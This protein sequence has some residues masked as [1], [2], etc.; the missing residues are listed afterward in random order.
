MCFSMQEVDYWKY[1]H[2][3]PSI[4]PVVDLRAYICLDVM[5]QIV[6]ADSR[7]CL[8]VRQFACLLPMY[9][10]HLLPTYLAFS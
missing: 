4:Q 2:M 9:L 6:F 3:S 7:V 10:F 1:F 5:L 8:S